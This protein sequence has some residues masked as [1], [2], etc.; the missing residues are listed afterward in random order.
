MVCKRKCQQYTFVKSERNNRMIEDTF[1]KTLVKYSL[2]TYYGKLKDNFLSHL[3]CVL[4]V[5]LINPGH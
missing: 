2:I 3:L 5:F 4:T 1:N